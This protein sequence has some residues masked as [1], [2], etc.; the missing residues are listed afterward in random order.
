MNNTYWAILLVQTSFWLPTKNQHKEIG[1]FT[2]NMTEC[3]HTEYVAR[4]NITLQ[5]KVGFLYF[6]SLFFFKCK[7][8]N[9]YYRVKLEKIKYVLSIYIKFIFPLMFPLEIY[10]VQCSITH[11]KPDH[12][13]G[14]QVNAINRFSLDLLLLAK[15]K[16]SNYLANLKCTFVEIYS[17]NHINAISK[18]SCPGNV[19][20]T[21][22]LAADA[23]YMPWLFYLLFISVTKSVCCGF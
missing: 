4:T 22:C 21:I 16:R 19:S 2:M 17:L 3:L 15:R 13:I 20:C 6:V 14:A 7:I 18:N 1:K 9:T 8:K 11:I 12:G 5:E 10:N 23:H